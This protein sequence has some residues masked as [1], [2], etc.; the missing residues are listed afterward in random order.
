[1]S[2]LRQALADYLT[3]RRA[4]GFKL[5]QHQRLLARFI[6]YLE[7]RQS[8]AITVKDAVGWVSLPPGA[9]DSWLGI[10]MNAVRGFA[11]YLHT[12]DPDNQVPPAGLLPFRTGRAVPYLYS[13]ADLDALVTAAEN[14]RCALRTLT[15]QTLIGLLATTGMRVGEAVRLDDDD[16]DT[17][18]GLLAV[19]ESKLGKSRLIPLH[20]TAVSALRDYQHLRDRLHPPPHTP[21]IFMSLAGTR[22][23]YSS[24]WHTF[25]KL[26][27]L[28]GLQPRSAA[29]RP[30]IHDLRHT[31]AVATLIDWYQ[32][33]GPVQPRLPLLSTYLGHTAPAN[34]YW[35]L[36]AAPE[37]LA[38]A[39]QRLETH[40]DSRP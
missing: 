17:A 34:T 28:A 16:F 6:G 18:S 27:H 9:S 2:W 23:L 37:L 30:R 7:D 24:V 38:L 14:L 11:A 15:Y 1:M 12:I 3:M 26:V 35:Y 5:E 21:A 31:F 40:L 20:P 8:A 10:R 32:D 25:A 19:R 36:Q 4:L 22:L 13:A 39:G 33:G 29:C